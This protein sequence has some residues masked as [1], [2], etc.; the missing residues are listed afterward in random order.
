MSAHREKIKALIQLLD[1]PNAE[2]SSAVTRNILDHGMS[3]LPDLEAAWERSPDH[4]YQ[5]RIVGL[6]QEIQTRSANTELRKWLDSEQHNLING[7]YIL[8]KY[9]YPA[10][11]FSE[12]EDPLEKIIKDVWLEL[13]NNLTA[14]EK[15]RI[16][17]HILF[18]V[19]KFR[20]STR[21]FY[22][23]RNSY[24]NQ[25]L[26]TKKGNPVSLSV[27]YSII[28]QRLG[29]PVYGVNL[30]KNFILAYKD[31]QVG[32]DIF[33]SFTE[34]ILFYINPGNRG[35]VLGKKQIDAF[36]KDQNLKARQSYYNPCSNSQILVRILHNL[37][38]AYY[39]SGYK[40]K[41]DQFKSVLRIFEMEG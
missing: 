28:A 30:P 14:L 41:A 16:L 11:A 17:N 39:K 35:A 9:Q 8:A 38:N 24:I 26:V 25:V 34:N 21:D 27:I 18:D 22:N 15:V 31:E 12:I 13:N 19:H 37:I 33:D 29:L 6:I 4:N 3:I 40:E 20:K 5:E 1:D 7:V 23:P 36:L 32:P 10:L 2:V